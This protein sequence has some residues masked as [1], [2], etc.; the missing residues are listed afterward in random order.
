MSTHVIPAALA[1]FRHHNDPLPRIAT[2]G[3]RCCPTKAS[4]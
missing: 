2:K 3:A 1:G 4:M